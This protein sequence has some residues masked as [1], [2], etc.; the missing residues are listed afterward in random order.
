M[1]GLL[2]GMGAAL[3]ALAAVA[4]LVVRAMQRRAN[5]TVVKQVVEAW[6]HRIRPRRRIIEG[7]R[8][9]SSVRWS[10][11][12]ALYKLTLWSS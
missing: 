4:C 6:R 2:A 3:L 5:V 10:P 11:A 12:R 7:F 8:R 9:L 1:V